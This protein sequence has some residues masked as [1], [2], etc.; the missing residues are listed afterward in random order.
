M[1]LG[2]QMFRKMRSYRPSGAMLVALLAL[3]LS[4][5]GLGYAGQVVNLLDGHQIKKG[6]IEADRLSNKARAALRGRSGPRGLRGAKGDPGPQGATGTRGAPGAAGA[7]GTAVAYARITVTNGSVTL[8]ESKNLSQS[9]VSAATSNP[10]VVCFHDLGFTVNSMVAS[11]VGVYGQATNNRTFVSV[12][13]HA[14]AQGCPPSSPAT[15]NTEA[16]VTAYDASPLT[17]PR[18]F[19]YDIEVWFQ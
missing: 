14:L 1:G 12:G 6:T 18:E 8:K 9:Q 5:G 10:G 3:F 16:F 17:G 13:P 19:P 15:F 4:L 7:P 11:P 2:G